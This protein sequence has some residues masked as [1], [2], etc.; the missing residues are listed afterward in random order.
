[1]IVACGVHFIRN[2]KIV[3]TKDVGDALRANFNYDHLGDIETSKCF[4]IST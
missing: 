1:M 3:Q 2:C 4:E